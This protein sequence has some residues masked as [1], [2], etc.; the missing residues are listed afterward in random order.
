MPVMDVPLCVRGRR[1]RNAGSSDKTAAIANGNLRDIPV[2][3]TARHS[4]A[5]L[6]I[7]R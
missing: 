5:I 6:E 1:E 2:T 7:M 3:Y 4:N